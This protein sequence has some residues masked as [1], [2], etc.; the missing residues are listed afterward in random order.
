METSEEVREKY[1]F[2][3]RD[4]QKDEETK[5]EEREIVPV[6]QLT[7]AGTIRTGRCWVLFP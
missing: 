6:K 7:D 1:R 2:L 5:K 3:V 4:R